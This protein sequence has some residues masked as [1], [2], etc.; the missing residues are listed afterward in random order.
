MQ[1]VFTELQIFVRVF[2]DQNTRQNTYYYQRICNFEVTTAFVGVF[3]A[4][5]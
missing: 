5:W 2:N 3:H 1:Q 4:H